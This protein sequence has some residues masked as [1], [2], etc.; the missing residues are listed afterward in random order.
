MQ[1]CCCWSGQGQCVQLAGHACRSEYILLLQY[2]SR[3]CP[4]PEAEPS[5][6]HYFLQAVSCCSKEAV[7][8]IVRQDAGRNCRW[9]LSATG[10]LV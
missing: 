1:H 6:R 7:S 4:S 2:A 3:E 9:V 8:K 10:F 5:L